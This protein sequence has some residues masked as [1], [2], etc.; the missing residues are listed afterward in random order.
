M[1]AL[2]VAAV[3]KE[4]AATAEVRNEI[5][6]LEGELAELQKASAGERT[7]LANLR[8]LTKQLEAQSDKLTRSIV[9]HKHLMDLEFVVCPRCGTELDRHRAGQGT[10]NL[11]LQLPSLTFSRDTL[12]EE[13]G[14]IEYQLSESQDLLRER[15]SRA[16]DLEVRL[17]QSRGELED[18]KLELEFQTR[19][20]VSE[21]AKRIAS[22]AAERAQLIAR[23]RQLHDYLDVLAKIDDTERIAA[24]FSVE[25]DKLVQQLAAASAKS[26][27]G[28]RRVESLKRYFNQIL[29]ELK[30]P[31]FGEQDVSGIS[32]KTYLPDYY[33]R[34]F[35]ELSS[36]GLATLVNLAHALAHHLTAIELGLKLPQ[37]LIIDG[38]SEHLG[39]EGLDPVRLKAAYGVLMRLAETHSELQIILVDN[40]IP[41]EA[42]GFVRLELSE[43]DRLIREC[44]EP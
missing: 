23:S 36:P 12:V 40:E 35:V 26:N 44:N 15:E 11:C 34:T 8:G 31:K 37:M 16:A 28:Y 33:G 9:S 38:L 29:E 22:L 42:R 21:E 17:T 5:L 7:S 6:A 24:K 3:P 20:Y 4:T 1:A 43:E 27:E 39:Q 30:P 14:A 18:R 32:P 19:S 10:C 13:Q 2:G 25:K 41:D